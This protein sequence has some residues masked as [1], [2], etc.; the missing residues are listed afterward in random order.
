MPESPFSGFGM[1]FAR[2]AA[3]TA[4][5][6]VLPLES[7]V[8]LLWRAWHAGYLGRLKSDLHNVLLRARFL[9]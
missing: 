8:L 2:W 1:E 7:G 4:V 3:A 5:L 9:S 6:A